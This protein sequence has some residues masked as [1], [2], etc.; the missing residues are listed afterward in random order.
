MCRHTYGPLVP[1]RGDVVAAQSVY[2]GLEPILRFSPGPMRVDQN[3]RG[4]ML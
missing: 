3:I 4:S 1:E 2:Y